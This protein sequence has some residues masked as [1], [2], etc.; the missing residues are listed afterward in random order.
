MFFLLFIVSI[1]S[2]ILIYAGSII[3]AKG[4][5]LKI[6]YSLFAPVGC[7][8]VVFGFLSGILHAKSDSA[9]S[10]RGRIYSMKE[11]PQSSIHIQ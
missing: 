6:S 3:E 11:H 1:V 8:I 5:F 7:F 4:L 9:I 10:W 2:S